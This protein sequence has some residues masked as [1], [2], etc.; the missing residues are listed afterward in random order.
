MR[1]AWHRSGASRA[2][3]L[4]VGLLTAELLVLGATGVW[5][6][7]FYVPSSASLWPLHRGLGN[8][9]SWSHTVQTIHR[10]TSRIAIPTAV[11][12][13]VLV[14]V[15]ARSRN[16]GWRKGRAALVAGPGIA[17]LVLAASFTGYLLPWDQVALRAVT[18]G[19]NMR[20][21]TPVFGS[22]VRYVLLGSNEISKSTMW[23]WFTVHT[24]VLSVLLIVTLIIAWCPRRRDRQQPAESD[25]PENASPTPSE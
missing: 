7:F 22:S 11:T 12:A 24:M 4:A 19:T 2:R 6:V 14:V 16:S 8:S 10:V 25:S 17:V 18:V 1:A 13:A 9:A 3:I 21:F 5:L 20:G 15:D 23:R